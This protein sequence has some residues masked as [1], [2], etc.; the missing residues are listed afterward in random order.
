MAPTFGVALL[1]AAL[2]VWVFPKDFYNTP[3]AG[4]S[5]FF[6]FGTSLLGLT[7]F[8]REMAGNTFSLLL[9]Q[10]MERRTLWK[11]KLIVVLIA[12]LAISCAWAVSCG[13]R[14]EDHIGPRNL[15]VNNSHDHGDWHER[16]HWR[17]RTTLLVT[18]VAGVSVELGRFQGRAIEEE[19]RLVERRPPTLWCS[20]YTP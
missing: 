10:P 12:I 4:A 2:P 17:D 8:G 16:A 9:S 18:T 7:S 6:W 5:Y 20:S 15:G 11:T 13:V 3:A 1:L 14:G 19:T